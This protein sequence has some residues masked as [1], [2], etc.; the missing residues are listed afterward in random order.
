MRALVIAIMLLQAAAP[1]LGVAATVD[2]CED[3]VAAVCGARSAEIQVSANQIRAEV[4]KA[5]GPS[6]LAGATDDAAVDG[7][8]ISKFKKYIDEVYKSLLAHFAKRGISEAA[9][10][11]QVKKIQAQ[12]A[13]EYSSGR[14][15]VPTA[16]AHQLT[17]AELAKNAATARMV[18]PKDIARLPA[19]VFKA[20]ADVERYYEICGADGLVSQAYYRASSHEIFLCP[21]Y[22]LEVLNSG[23]LEMMNGIVAHELTHATIS[24]GKFISQ[25]DRYS[26]FLSCIQD[27]YSGQLESV[28]H[29]IS[30]LGAP[31]QARL[32][33]LEKELL[34][35]PGDHSAELLNIRNSM[36]IARDQVRDIRNIADWTAELLGRVPNVA[37]MHASELVADLGAVRAAVGMA[38]KLPQSQRV[39]ALS[40]ALRSSCARLENIA[41]VTKYGP[42]K[43]DGEHTSSE[44]RIINFFNAPEVRLALGCKRLVGPLPWC[45]PKGR[46][47]LVAHCDLGSGGSSASDCQQRVTHELKK[48]NCK[49]TAADCGASDGKSVDCV[50]DSSNCQLGQYPKGLAQMT[51]TDKSLPADFSATAPPVLGVCV[52]KPS[53]RKLTE[54]PTPPSTAGTAESH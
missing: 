14:M 42:L 34:A 53:S 1:S 10:T 31:A 49:I 37:E 25:L 46:A 19:G 8:A 13:H 27:N 32:V 4:K 39:E 47:P 33:A 21:G 2:P 12:V 16:G 43:E 18:G 35:R 23:T 28:E 24:H 22:L 5:L 41:K 9:I 36:R 15:G 45:G 30:E 52:D 51:C 17:N 11:A 40:K 38:R 50:I 44:F 3:P 20:Q 48:A 54:T 29:V 6:A 26:D 7:V